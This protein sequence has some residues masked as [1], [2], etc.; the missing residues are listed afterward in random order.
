MPRP[1]ILGVVGDSATGKTTITRGLVRVLGEDAVTHVCT[2]DYHKY[3]RKAR[4]ENGMTPLN[5]DCNYLDIIAQ[6]LAH[7]RKGEPILKPTYLH[8]D[9]T[10][11][12]PKYVVPGRFAVIEGLLGYHTGPLRDACD[13]RVYLAPPEELRR[14]WKVQRDC[15]RRG[16]TTDEVL[17][18]LDRR[19]HDSA[20]FIRPQRR[21]ADIVISFVPHADESGDPDHLDAELTLRDGLVHPDLSPVIDADSPIGIETRLGERF[22]RIPGNLEA[23]QGA[24]I[25]EAIWD[26][27]HFASHLR[28]QRLGEFT[29]GTDL[30]RSESLALVQLL[31]LYHMAT[32]KAAI[33]LGGDGGRSRQESPPANVTPEP[34][35]ATA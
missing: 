30:H 9:G 21:H 32:A 7:F 16:Y 23:T 10:F 15:S 4:A 31:I 17:A 12:A 27:M 5:P 35:A 19:E 33:A 14:H 11:G 24:R 25:E 8:A 18:E 2:D 28:T 26:R 13:V 3:D 20:S 1:V 34:E 22:L 29:V 6:D